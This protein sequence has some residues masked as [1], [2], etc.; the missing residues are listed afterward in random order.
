MLVGRFKFNDS[1]NKYSILYY[2]TY[3]SGEKSMKRLGSLSFDLDNKWSYMKTFGVHGSEKFPSYFEVL[4]PYM[5]EVLEA[6]RLKITFFV[7][8]QDAALNSNKEYL[9]LI[10]VHGHEIGNHSYNHEPW[11]NIY[12][13]SRLRREVIE[14]DDLIY[15]ITGQKPL[16]FRAPGFSWTKELAD[17]LIS[18]GYIYDASTLPCYITILARI[19]FFRG[20]NLSSSVKKKIRN[21][22]DG[23]SEGRRPI[24]PYYWN[25]PNRGYLLEIPVTT[26]P[27]FKTPFHLSY[28]IFLAKLSPIVMNFY[29]KL[30]LSLIK[31][32]NIEPSFL[33]HPTDILGIEQVPDMNFFPG[34]ALSASKKLTILKNVVKEI[35]KHYKLV[36]MKEHA[37]YIS[38]RNDIKKRPI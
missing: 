15:K 37:R 14:T 29:L 13:K 7:V 16:G 11:L 18:Q 17:I 10:N 24:M 3:K 32:K 31:A 25:V 5:L 4:I 2:V 6:M 28:L 36:K 34:M 35:S 9:K 12:S 23:F 8:G 38:E 27:I 20:D 26:V 22:S 19:Y 21:S 1:K 33:I 30:G